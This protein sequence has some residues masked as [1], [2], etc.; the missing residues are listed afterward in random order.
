MLR[1]FLLLYAHVIL[2]FLNYNKKLENKAYIIN[3][4]IISFIIIAV[5]SAIRNLYFSVVF[6]EFDYYISTIKE[7]TNKTAVKTVLI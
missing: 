4:L 3:L 6:K 1:N 2:G 7:S 5:N